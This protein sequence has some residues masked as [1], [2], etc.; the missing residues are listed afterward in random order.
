[1]VTILCVLCIKSHKYSNTIFVICF[2]EVIMLYLNVY[3]LL[4]N[5]LGFAFMLFDKQSAIKRKRRIPEKLLFLFSL[6]GGSI[7]VFWGMM[8]FRHKTKHLMFTL[9]IPILASVHVIGYFSLSS[10]LY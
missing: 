10:S 8:F 7:G 6:L 4:I 1:M 5:A 3:M 2:L 9:L